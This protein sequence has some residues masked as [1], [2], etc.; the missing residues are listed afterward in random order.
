M[1]HI[2]LRVCARCACVR[3]PGRVRE[4]ICVHSCSLAY[5]TCKP[6][7]H[8][9]TSFVA[10]LVPLYFLTLSHKGHDFREKVIE[11]KMCVLMFSTTSIWNIS[12]S[13]KNAV[14]Y[15]H[16]CEYVFM[17]PLFFADFN[18]TWIFRTD[19][20]KKASILN[21]IKIRP[22]GAELFHADW[23]MDGRTRRNLILKAPCILYKLEIN[24]KS[25]TIYIYITP[26]QMTRLTVAFRNFVNSTTIAIVLALPSSSYEHNIGG[27]GGGN[28]N[29][30]I[31]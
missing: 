20:R 25:Q 23:Q 8:I 16:K 3:V 22:V 24:I 18:E 31:F 30:T 7:R 27:G 29:G 11:H 1:L 5:P 17:Y 6:M 13:N 10:F 15:C 4:C 21:L 28:K 26:T 9:V 14:R 12:Y 2:C 19:F